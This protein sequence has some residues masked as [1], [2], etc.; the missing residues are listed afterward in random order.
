MK[1]ILLS[2]FVTLAMVAAKPA[3]PA[4][5]IPIKVEVVGIDPTN[6]Y[7]DLTLERPPVSPFR[8]FGVEMGIFKKGKPGE[9]KRYGV[10]FQGGKK[11][12]A[13]G[14]SKHVYETI[15]EP[16]MLQEEGWFVRVSRL[17]VDVGGG[18]TSLDAWKKLH[19][20]AWSPSAPYQPKLW[21]VTDA[22]PTPGPLERCTACNGFGRVAAKKGNKVSSD[23]D[24]KEPCQ[25]CKGVGKLQRL[26]WAAFHAQV[27]QEDVAWMQK[28]A[29]ERKKEQLKASEAPEWKDFLSEKGEE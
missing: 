21:A 23:K 16:G 27:T 15:T 18:G 26:Q 24:N 13:C 17:G 19:P 1:T 11:F 20:D 28:S 12:L 10:V 14:N 2:L 25:D 22:A 8:V 9:I 7:V 4:K 29:E 5:T 3:K 6:T